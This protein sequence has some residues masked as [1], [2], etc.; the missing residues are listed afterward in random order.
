MVPLADLEFAQKFPF[1]KTGKRVIKEL[2]VSFDG[3]GEA[4]K[5][6]AAARLKAAFKRQAYFQPNLEGH[7]EL[8][9]DE[10]L[11]YTLA[12]IYISAI[13]NSR[14]YSQFARSNAESAFSR[15]EEERRETLKIRMAQEFGFDFGPTEE[16]RYSIS[17]A[18]FLSANTG[19]EVLKLVNQSVESGRVEL[20]GERFSRLLSEKAFNEVLE[21]LPSKAGGVPES[22]KAEALA[23]GEAFVKKQRAAFAKISGRAR[24]ELFPPCMEKM[25]ADLLAGKNLPHLARFDLST[26]LNAVG[27]PEEEI[28][29]A[30]GNASNYNEKT[31]RYQVR[32]ILKGGRQG[33]GYSPASCAK[34]KTHTLCVAQCNV[35]HPAQYYRNMLGEAKKA[36]KAA[37]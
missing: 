14:L 13:N 4:A 26:F 37:K 9:E 32:K 23:L 7:R 15:L 10:I 33:K 5:K 12:K 31:T 34:I 17:V 2:N 36:K 11:S 25:Y 28:I 1:T 16:G 3:L 29:K 24:P 21:S 8:L 18:D 20:N 6:S 35:K 27:M 22:V 19:I 30:F